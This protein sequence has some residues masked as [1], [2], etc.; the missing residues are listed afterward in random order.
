MNNH[1]ILFQYISNLEIVLPI[2]NRICIFNSLT[3]VLFPMFTNVHCPQIRPKTLR[4][5][6]ATENLLVIFICL[7]M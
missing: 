2:S 5:N 7:F 3:V 4:T 6:F 1:F